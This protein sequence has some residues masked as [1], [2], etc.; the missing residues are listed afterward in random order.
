MTGRR[1]SGP[2]RGFPGRT[3][4]LEGLLLFLAAFLGTVLAITVPAGPV[5]AQEE[6]ADVLVAQAVLAYEE[7]RYQDALTA[8]QEALQLEPENTDALYYT[9]LVRV[10]L[11]QPEQAVEALEKARALHPTDEA[12]QFQL[13]IVYFSLSKY[14]QAQPLLEAVFTTNPK[15]D[16]LGYYVG[17]MRYRNKDYQ[18]ALAAFRAG[19]SADP[20]VQ[21]LTKFYTGLALGILGLPER[22]AAEIAEAM[23]LAPASPLTG[24]AERLRGPLVA[25]GERERPY[26]LE[27]RVGGNYDDNVSVIPNNRPDSLVQTLRNQIHRSYGWLTSLRAEYT[28]KPYQYF[29]VP[30]AN[31]IPLSLTA[32]YTFFTSENTDFHRFNIMDHQGDLRATYGGTIETPLGALGQPEFKYAYDYL[33]LGGDEF[34]SRHTVGPSVILGEGE[35]NFTVFQAGYQHKRYALSPNPTQAEKRD[36]SN[37]MGGFLHFLHFSEKRPLD[38]HFVKAGYQADWDLIQGEDFTYF[39]N[40]ILAGGQYT[41]PWDKPFGNLRFTYDFNVH[42]RNY[43]NFNVILPTGR[44]NSFARYDTE[45]THV[46]RLTYPLTD[47]LP[48]LT[49]GKVPGT[50]SVS[51]DFQASIARS[52]LD[53]FTFNRNVASLS[54]IWSY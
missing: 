3:S 13:G 10:A 9:G 16:G 53:T 32:G 23:R 52:N 25:A 41:F 4:T 19:A 21:Q 46:A 43:R 27:V 48:F 20:N 33:T 50:L 44:A 24:P 45:Y 39:G 14:D 28:L 35:Q 40:R 47:N 31:L 18:G 17:F 37:Y 51:A 1:V 26:H 38:K 2:R 22:A 54:L 36:G 12:I 7:K 30:P 15:L 29:E 34:V 5:G 49:G 42:F 11:G 6:E 8:L